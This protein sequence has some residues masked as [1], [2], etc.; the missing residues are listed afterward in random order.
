MNGTGGG[1]LHI[2]QNNEA[3]GTGETPLIQKNGDPACDQL[4]TTGFALLGLHEAVAATGD[5]ELKKAEDK[6]ADFLVRVQ[7]RSERHPELSG[8]WMRAFD[9]QRWD[10]WAS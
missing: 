8:A 2:P 5:V 10:Y 9:F 6:L 7:T 4:Y 3:Y 1:H